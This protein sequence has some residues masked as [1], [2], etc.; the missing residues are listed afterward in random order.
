MNDEPIS[1]KERRKARAMVRDIANQCTFNGERLCADEWWIVVFAGAYGQEVLPNPFHQQFPSA[2]MFI[3]RN[4]KRTAHLTVSTGAELITA[5]YAFGNER[6]VS[7]SDLKWKA[8][9]EAY[10]RM[11]QEPMRIAA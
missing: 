1:A 5:L 3:V 4:K 9:M 8:D 6:C 7:W 2:P 10:A 11:A